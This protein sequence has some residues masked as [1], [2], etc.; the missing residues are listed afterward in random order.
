MMRPIITDAFAVD[1]GA[2]GMV[3]RIYLAAEDLDGDMDRIAVRVHQIG[4]GSYPTDWIVLKTEYRFHL[5]GY[6]QWNTFSSRAP[7]LRE[8]TRLT[9]TVSIVDKGGNESDEVSFPL[10]FE[11]GAIDAEEI[12]LPPPFSGRELPRLGHISIDL[13][14]GTGF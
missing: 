4:Y 2:Y 11:S 10:T 14:E 1:R 6:L 5:L 8:W 7:S 13:M 12:P 3:W 9:V